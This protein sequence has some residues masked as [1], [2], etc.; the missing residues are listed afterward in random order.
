MQN[1]FKDWEAVD[2]NRDEELNFQEFCTLIRARELDTHTDQE[3]YRWHAT[4]LSTDETDAETETASPLKPEMSIC[5][6][7][8]HAPLSSACSRPLQ[9]GADFELKLLAPLVRRRFKE[10][11]TT[12]D[13]KL[14]LHEYLRY[15]LRDALSRSVERGKR[16]QTRGER[17]ESSGSPG[18]VSLADSP[19]VTPANTPANT[20]ADSPADTPA[21]TPADSPAET[22]T[23]PRWQ[24]W[25]LRRPPSPVGSFGSLQPMGH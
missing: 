14:Q 16:N 5:A 13:G 6:T 12:G 25:Q 3:L 4:E 18:S 20:P 1:N 21:D 22:R 23:L 9:A 24:L 7:S 2:S 11:D 15:S 17:T 19:A 10:L 8:V